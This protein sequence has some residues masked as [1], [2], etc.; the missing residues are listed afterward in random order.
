MLI[1]LEGGEHGNRSLGGILLLMPP[2]VN[3]TAGPGWPS[4]PARQ[5]RFGRVTPKLLMAGGG[6]SVERDDASPLRHAIRKYAVPRT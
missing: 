6:W 1:R 5:Q 4:G 2:T 3:L